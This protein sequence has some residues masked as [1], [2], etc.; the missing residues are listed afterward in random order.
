MGA[1]G[2]ALVAGCGDGSDD[3][4]DGAA[5]GPGASNGLDFPG[6]MPGAPLPTGMPGTDPSD[7]TAG[8]G[9]PLPPEI[10][11]RVD[12]ELPQASERF[13]YAANPAGG[14]VSII[15]AESLS[16]QTLETGSRPTFLRTLAGTD[17]AIVL[18]AGSD[19]ATV[20]RDPASGARTSTVDVVDGANAIAV[21]PDGKHAVVYFDS[22]FSTADG[23][24][25]S[26]QDV[27][28]IS[29]DPA[30][31]S[32]TDM[33][34]GFRP[35]A[36]AFSEDGTTGY[37]VTEDGVSVLDFEA[38]ES[39]GTG[40]AQ[41]ISLGEN[42]DQ[43]S[44]D[45]SITPDGRHALTRQP[46]EPVLR[47]V[48][49]R[50]GSLTTLGLGGLLPDD[51]GGSGDE[52]AGVPDLPVEVTDLDLSPDGTFALA[53][54]RNQSAVLR[55]PVP[56]GFSDPGSIEVI[57]VEGELIGS[58]SI[59][60]AG[61]RALLYTTAVA[62]ERI[63]VVPLSGNADHE[64]V[65]LRKAVQAVSIAPDGET[66]VIVHARTEGDP[67]EPGIDPDLQIDR[68]FGYSLLRIGSGDVKLQVTE[69]EPGTITL[70]PDGSFVF[71]LFRDDGLAV[72]EVQQIE[73]KSFL[74]E[75][76]R[77]GSPPVSLGAV[78][79]SER[80]FVGQEH[81]DGRVTFIDWKTSETQTVT[82]FELNS[83]IRD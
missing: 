28:V 50:D 63:T 19:D 59:A 7:G 74:V 80:V 39:E 79:Q 51:S 35:R 78:P 66:A 65:A 68:S 60:P 10:E 15:D 32:A 82:G 71:I 72:R 52:D 53:V 64:T 76:I 75:P 6:Q 14:T 81:P 37:V 83:R 57:D 11:V 62:A 13:V 45:V 9:A 70:V 41:L 36:V 18:N 46:G 47:L 23:G 5:R 12:F 49:L 69:T 34:V 20:M 33:T 61:D 17:D 77:L 56:S 31:D 24:S 55:I 30:G 16:I 58:V 2:A 73:A 26:F 42:I 44:L 48:D 22:A 38:V 8:D 27:T 67:N 29:L 4:A 25:G 43:E 21:S 54:L 40:I 3:S 1:L